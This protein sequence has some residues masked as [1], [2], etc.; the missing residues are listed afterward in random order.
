MWSKMLEEY[1]ANLLKLNEKPEKIRALALFSGGLDSVLAAYL[2]AKQDIEV[3]CLHFNTGFLTGNHR[4]LV[5]LW[6]KTYS[7]LNFEYIDVSDEY[8]DVLRN[9]KFGYGSS[10]NP[11]IDC[12]LFMI[13]QAAL[14]LPKFNAHFII[15]GEV[16][17]QRPK[18]QNQRAMEKIVDESGIS[19]FLLRPLSAKI[20]EETVPE[21][22]GWINRNDLLD[23]HGRSRQ[24]Q[25]LLAKELDVPILS[26]PGSDACNLLESPFSVRYFDFISHNEQK[27]PTKIDYELLKFG[28][29]FRISKNAKLIVGRNEAENERLL[30]LHQKTNDNDKNS[31][32]VMQVDEFPGPIALL[33]KTSD[34]SQDDIKFA[35]SIVVKYSKAP[36]NKQVKV[37][38][39]DNEQQYSIFVESAEYSAIFHHSLIGV[40]K[41]R[42]KDFIVPNATRNAKLYKGK[43][44]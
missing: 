38:C 1:I 35:A 25:L 9:P 24:K 3:T 31:H 4:K 15:T 13:R 6:K 18:S 39:I 7:G 2:V 12:H 29:H 14:Q 26:K 27:E 21:R 44:N 22:R 33:E 43:I 41:N 11:C 23:I 40:P 30:Q 16:R 19:G 36:S 42:P 20:L 10:A 5:E 8:L 32:I 34:I 37:N 17:G 28:R